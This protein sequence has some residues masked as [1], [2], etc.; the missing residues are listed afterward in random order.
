MKKIL[1]LYLFLF[2]SYSV[3]KAQDNSQNKLSL[4]PQQIEAIFLENNLELIA[5]KMNIDL[6][7]AEIIQAKLWDNPEISI[8][9]I[10]L[11]TTKEQREEE[12]IPALIGNKFLK[13]TQFSIELS[14]LIQ[15]ANKRGRLVK[16]E[17]V[18]K[19][20]VKKEFEEL[21]RGLKLE[22]RNSINEVSYLQHYLKVIEEQQK[23]LQGLINAYAKQVSDGNIAKVELVRLK[24]ALLEIDNEF[25]ETKSEYNNEITALKVLLSVE[26]QVE[27]EI[28]NNTPT[29]L[30]NPMEIALD[31]LLFDAELNR[32]DIN[33][34]K[35]QT[36][37]QEKNLAYEKALRVP[38]ITLQ[39]NYDRR[40]GIW[41]DY[42]GFGFS[43]DLPFFDRNQGGIKA[44]KI[45]KE[46]SIYQSKFELNKMKNEVTNAYN[47]YAVAYELYKRSQVDNLQSELTSMQQ[48][49]AKYLLN[50]TIS[51]VEYLDFIE[52][53]KDN[54]NTILTAEKQVKNQ[55]E[56][57]QFTI[58]TDLN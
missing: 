7:D 44:A 45:S 16:R 12:P 27:L 10:N 42:V 35:L 58:A 24:S 30:I 6:A 2:S 52:A 29:Q 8:G 56:E 57:L 5:E 34:A 19:Q 4:S 49:Y 55:F 53:Y 36:E 33:A 25:F 31:N 21:L 47:N 41:K 46:Q 3:L 39:A 15:T 14:Q 17:K 38:D 26:P 37:Y 11:W 18:S 50:K 9:D 1:F 51:M 28:I 54:M 23:S 20:I 13:N 40:G 48:V 32:P 43:M 22:L